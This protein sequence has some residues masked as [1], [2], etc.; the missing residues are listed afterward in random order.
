MLSRRIARFIDERLGAARFA[1]KALD[2]TFPDHFSFM[3]GEI[4]LY[5]FMVLVITGVFLTFFFEPS[6]QKVTYNGS[7]H[8]LDGVQMSA[9]YRSAVRLSFDVRAGLVMRQI[10]HWAALCFLA[11]IVAHLCRIFFTGAFRK[12]RDINWLVGVTLLVLA[13]ANGFAGYS[14]LDDLLSGTGLRIMYS[15]VQSIPLVGNW[16]AF[17]IFGGEYPASNI[18]SRL[19]VVHILLLPAAIATLIGVHLAVIW[20]QKHTQFPGPGRT[21][22]NVIGSRLFPTYAAKSISLFLGV[23]AV[24]SVLGGVAQINPVWLYGPYDASV[25]SIAAQ[26][27]WYV[28]WLEGALRLMPPWELRAWGFEIPN[29]FYPAILL[30]GLT[31][32][33]LYLWP[34]IE[35][36]VTRDDK[37][38]NLLDRPR[39]CPTRTAIGVGALVFYIV[40][41]IAGGSDVIARTIH[42]SINAEVWGLRVLLFVLPVLAALLTWSVCRSLAR[43]D[44]EKSADDDA[45]PPAGEPWRVPDRSSPEEVVVPGLLGVGDEPPPA[46]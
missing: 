40:L 37:I 30:P 45:A 15:L 46:G 34:F 13:L 5:C 1:R 24:I 11:A 39:D 16:I 21:E 10:H 33:L 28:G 22:H 23:F 38:H 8:A 43:G 20:H 32:L 7:Y 19:F 14:L 25:V 2:K 4:A 6:L 41:F 36:K 9:A 42:I 35:R 12:P 18:I 3:L 27:D 31:F 44:A 17:L 26:P 29:P